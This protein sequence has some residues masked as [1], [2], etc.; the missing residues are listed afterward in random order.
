[1]R[2]AAHWEVDN[3]GRVGPARHFTSGGV[4]ANLLLW[5]LFAIVLGDAD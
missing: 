4:V 1:V 5:V 2:I 3:L